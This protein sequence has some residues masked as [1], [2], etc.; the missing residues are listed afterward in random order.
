MT[1]IFMQIA[2]DF[3][4]NKIAFV[5]THGLFKKKYKRSVCDVS[6]LLLL[7]VLISKLFVVEST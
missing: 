2:L 4:E 6:E 3:R 7:P 1:T 5:P